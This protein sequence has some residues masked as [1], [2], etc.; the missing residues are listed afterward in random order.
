MNEA[1]VGP[2][3]IAHGP[4]ENARMMHTCILFREYTIVYVIHVCIDLLRRGPASRS[5]GWLLQCGRDGRS[6]FFHLTKEPGRERKKT[7]KL[8]SAPTAHD[9]TSTH[10]AYR[11]RHRHSHT[12]IKARPAAYFPELGRPSL[13]CSDPSLSREE[14]RTTFPGLRLSRA[15]SRG[16]NS[17]RMSSKS[18]HP[19]LASPRSGLSCLAG[20]ATFLSA[21]L[22]CEELRLDRAARSRADDDLHEE[23]SERCEEYIALS[24]V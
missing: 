11:H 8:V 7:R 21:L 3:E 18:S 2:Q 10:D 15:E 16:G 20:A 19:P 14:Y 24:M 4:Q 6:H 12:C 23:R 9:H 1:H 22:S 13:S 17:V 5:A